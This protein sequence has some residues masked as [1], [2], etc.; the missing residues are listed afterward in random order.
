MISKKPADSHASL[1]QLV[2]PN[3]TN[4]SNNLMGGALLNKMDIVAGIA[5]QNHSNRLSVTASVDNVSFKKPISLGSIITITAKVT[6]AF[7]TSMEVKLVVTAKNIPQRVEEFIANEAF[8]TFVALDNDGYP[9][10]VP[11]I[12]TQTEVEKELYTGA[13]RRRELRLV[14]AE[15]MTL[16]DTTELKKILI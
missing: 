11:S 15:K 6:R 5:A 12:N 8:Y 10:T 2:L 13:M 4:M 16:D 14:L 9:C 7:N 3:D 1:S